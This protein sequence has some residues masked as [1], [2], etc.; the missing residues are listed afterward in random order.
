[1]S[2][3]AL[4]DAEIDAVFQEM[5][6]VGVSQR[7]DRSLLAHAAVF[8]GSSQAGLETG[9]RD[10][11]AVV[12]EA[13]LEPASGGGGEKPVGRAV[14]LPVFAEQDEGALWDRDDAISSTFSANVDDLALAIDVRSTPMATGNSRNCCR[15]VPIA[16]IFAKPRG[17]VLLLFFH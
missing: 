6:C 17:A 8:D 3:V 13:V 15:E 4:D 14:G 12:R 16:D 10:G 1:M 7:V 9:T 5:G 11:P 2:E